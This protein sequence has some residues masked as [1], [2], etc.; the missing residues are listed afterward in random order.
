MEARIH[1]HKK[2]WW[3]WSFAR[4]WPRSLFR[5]W[6]KRNEFFPS[7]WHV[8]VLALGYHIEVRFGYGR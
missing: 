1:E 7:V 5:A 2:W 3:A 8:G 6:C 4:G